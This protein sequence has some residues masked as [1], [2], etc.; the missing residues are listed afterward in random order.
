M[1]FTKLLLADTLKIFARQL[2][3][4]L[5]YPSS[6]ELDLNLKRCE[7]SSFFFSGL[8]YVL[9]NIIINFVLRSCG[10]NN[11]IIISLIDRFVGVGAKR[12]RSL[13][14]AAKKKV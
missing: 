2:L 3:E 12:V 1:P 7:P 10:F 8:A 5:E 4:K 11:N 6:I 9:S 14:Q 13:F